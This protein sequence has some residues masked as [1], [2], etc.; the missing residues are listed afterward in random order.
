ME[1]GQLPVVDGG[2][3]LPLKRVHEH[4]AVELTIG[5]QKVAAEIDTGNVGHG[6]LFPASLVEK[7]ALASKPA[8]IGQAR[9]ITSEFEIMEARLKDDI[10]LGKY[11]F[12]GPLISFPAPFPFANI[13]SKFLNQF[14]I[15][16]DQKK[17]RVRFVRPGKDE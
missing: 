11:E 13:G 6:F 14:A 4:P 7:L 9:T 5:N 2:E 17:N 10:R 16:F 1:H 3:V 8:T 12:K 15:T